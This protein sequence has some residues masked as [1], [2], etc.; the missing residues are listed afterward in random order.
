[1]PA[2]QGRGMEDPEGHLEPVGHSR[3]ATEVPRGQYRPAGQAVVGAT[4]PAGPHTNPAV[5][6]WHAEA[7][8]EPLWRGKAGE[9]EGAEQG[10]KG[11]GNSRKQSDKWSDGWRQVTMPRR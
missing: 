9:R 4:V 5:Q 8:V 2:G 10:A 3:V 6:G 7:F 11:E 1:V